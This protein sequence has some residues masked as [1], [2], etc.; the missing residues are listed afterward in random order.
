MQNIIIFIGPDN[1][2]KTSIAKQLANEI[3]TS[4]YRNNNAQ[5]YFLNKENLIKLY[6]EGDT[7]YNFI[8]QVNISVI[9]DRHFPCEYAYAHTYNRQTDD[10]YILNLDEKFSLLNTKL[11]Y[12]YKDIYKDFI[13][14][15]VKIEDVKKLKEHYKYYLENLTKCD[16]LMLNTTDEDI[17]NQIK[18]IKKFIGV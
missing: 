17:K 2:G 1:S 11:I 18:I 15:Y 10:N 16:Y 4:Y 14:E 9:F 5:K 3:N 12:C 6:I 8:K 7:L 13:D